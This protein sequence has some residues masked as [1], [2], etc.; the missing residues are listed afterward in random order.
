MPRLY[1]VCGPAGVGKSTY[2]KSLAAEKRAC[3]L[4]SD[5]VTEP[6]VRAGMV[7]GGFD[8]NDRDSEMYR[9]A[10]RTAVYECLFQTAAENL[11][12]VSVV[13]V[14]PFTSE[15]RKAEWPH[16]LA[17]RFSCE[18]EVI[19][20]TCPEDERCRRIKGRGNPRDELKL[21][22]WDGY[23]KRTDLRPPAFKYREITT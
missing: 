7:L 15:I 4:D 8:P 22:D 11:P 13:L 1:V 9:A 18:L 20:V 3:F 16:E 10:F 21:V 2:G 14:G 19:F 12:H 23:L 6:V 5:T 17:E